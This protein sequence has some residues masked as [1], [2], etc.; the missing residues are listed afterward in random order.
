MCHQQV[1]NNTHILPKHQ[2]QK[3]LKQC[4]LT[5]ALSG[6]G[7]TSLMTRTIAP[8]AIIGGTFSVYSSAM[9]LSHKNSDLTP[10]SI[11]YLLLLALNHAIMP[12]LSRRF[13]HPKTNKRSVALAEELVK[14]TLGLGGWWVMSSYVAASDLESTTSTT[15]PSTTT[16]LS[17]LSDQLQNWSPTSTLLAAGIPSALYALQAILT[18]NSYQNL[19]PVTYNSYITKETELHS[20]Y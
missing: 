18:Y 2:V 1:G 5:N 6:D 9:K 19:D 4:Q 8:M 7:H 3:Q 10:L 15:M 11:L 13:I 17:I 12:R 14:M 16:T 20:S